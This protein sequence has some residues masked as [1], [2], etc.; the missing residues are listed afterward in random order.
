MQ[1]AP[2]SV[3][4][5]SRL[6]PVVFYKLM[7]FVCLNQILLA[8][9][10]QMA[11]WCEAFCNYDNRAIGPQIALCW[12]VNGQKLVLHRVWSDAALIFYTFLFISIC[13]VHNELPASSFC[14]QLVWSTVLH[15]YHRLHQ[16]VFSALLQMKCKWLL[17]PFGSHSLDK[18][19]RDWTN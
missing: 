9:A 18:S 2:L 4:V 6:L 5:P 8:P 13:L 11:S 10:I 19:K 7:A 12:A 14:I 16:T 1:M 15:S 17:C 3:T